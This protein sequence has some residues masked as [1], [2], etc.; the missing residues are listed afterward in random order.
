MLTLT[1][2]G[3]CFLAISTKI[4]LARGWVLLLNAKRVSGE[5]TS[6]IKKTNTNEVKQARSTKDLSIFLILI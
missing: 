3:F 6:E 5:I 1:T 2:A 4:L